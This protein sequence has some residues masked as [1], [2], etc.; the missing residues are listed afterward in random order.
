MKLNSNPKADVTKTAIRSI[1]RATTPRKITAKSK[2]GKF[3]QGWKNRRLAKKGTNQIRSLAKEY[4]RSNEGVTKTIT[5]GA[6]QSVSSVAAAS[7]VQ[8]L[9]NRRNNNDA[10]LSAWTLN[11]NNNPNPSSGSEGQNQGNSTTKIG[12]GWESKL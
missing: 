5:R 7:T 1:E 4:L 6:T 8:D 12:G 11:M 2:I 10:N 9:D 3:Y